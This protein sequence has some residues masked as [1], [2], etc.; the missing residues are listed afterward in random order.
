[1]GHRE[2][3]DLGSYSLMNRQQSISLVKKIIQGS[4]SDWFDLHSIGI[5]EVLALFCDISHH[6]ATEV[7]FFPV[8][9]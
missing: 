4:S 9:H 6:C 3:T 1:M 7:I 2:R 8:S 5:S